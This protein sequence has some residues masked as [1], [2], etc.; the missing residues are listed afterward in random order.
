MLCSSL[1]LVSNPGSQPATTGT[2]C[3]CIAW[4]ASMVRGIQSGLFLSHPMAVSFSNLKGVCQRHAGSGSVGPNMAL[5]TFR[6]HKP[7]QAIL[8]EVC[9]MF[10]WS[11]QSCCP[12][13]PKRRCCLKSGQSLGNPELFQKWKQRAVHHFWI[14]LAATEKLTTSYEFIRISHQEKSKIIKS[15]QS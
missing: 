8:F 11:F 5:D 3:G 4:I 12:A 2:A 10:T 9:F 13:T 7:F 14:L 1:I 6:S 15:D